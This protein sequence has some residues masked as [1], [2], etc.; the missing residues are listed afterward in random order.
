MGAI[1]ILSGEMQGKT[2]YLAPGQ[3]L[4]IGRGAG[5]NIVLSPGYVHVSRQ[6]CF[7]TYDASRKLFYLKD[8]SSKGVFNESDQRFAGEGYLAAGSRIYLADRSC[9]IE[10]T[11]ASDG[12]GQVYP[13]GQQ[14][15]PQPQPQPQPRPQGYS[16]PPVQNGYGY[17]GN[18]T[19]GPNT[20]GYPMGVDMSETVTMGEWLTAMLL[21]SIPCVNVVLMLIWAFGGG[22]KKSKAN[23]FKAELILVGIYLVLYLFLV[24]IAGTLMSDLMSSLIYNLF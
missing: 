9:M 4:S 6:H 12:Q 16:I 11:A 18:Y 20:G 5:C 13:S 17:Q 22:T 19:P 10:L 24:V 21:M 14:Y 3:S 2:F 15:I 1:R 8:T 23:F 7:L